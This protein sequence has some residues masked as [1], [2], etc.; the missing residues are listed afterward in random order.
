MREKKSDFYFRG[1]IH[2]IPDPYNYMIRQGY[3]DRTM[4]FKPIFFQLFLVNENILSV[5]LMEYW[6]SFSSHPTFESC[7]NY[8]KIN[9]LTYTRIPEYLHC[10]WILLFTQVKT[11][12]LLNI[13]SSRMDLVFFRNI[14]P[15]IESGT[16]KVLTQFI[17]ICW[18]KKIFF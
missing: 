13:C 18:E 2:F 17:S 14:I 6:F 9:S 4:Q 10:I 11:F 1:L 8:E 5:K 3:K 7:I 15:C 12:L 16:P